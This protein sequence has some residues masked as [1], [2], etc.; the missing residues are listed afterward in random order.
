MKT[1]ISQI[2]VFQHLSQQY[3][4]QSVEVMKLAG[5][6]GK[7]WPVTG[8]RLVEHYP[9]L[10][11]EVRYA[12]RVQYAMNAVDVIARRTRLAFQDT[13]AARQA[14]PRVLEIMGEELNWTDDE[15]ER[16]N[17]DASNFLDTQM[18]Y[19]AIRSDAKMIPRDIINTCVNGFLEQ[20]PTPGKGLSYKHAAA[21]ASELH[22]GSFSE[23]E[24]GVILS[25]V[26]I[27]H[28][29]KEISA[30]EFLVLAGE[31][32]RILEHTASEERKQHLPFKPSPEETAPR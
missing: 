17:T 1:L 4:D 15:K 32:R 16:Q 9:Y 27:V 2:D 24:I 11:A 14:L 13:D 7:T 6:T 23:E 3:G 18:G 19:M 20:Q 26:N 22:L 25:N 10:E 29:V 8:V 28:R 21:L 31:L 12:V 30:L 5:L